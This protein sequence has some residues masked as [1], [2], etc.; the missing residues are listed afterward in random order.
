[1]T[2]RVSIVTFLS[3]LSFSGLSQVTRDVD[4]F[5][6]LVKQV[7]FDIESSPANADYYAIR[8]WAFYSLDSLSQANK[9]Y[10]RAI[11]LNDKNPDFYAGRGKIFFLQKD[12]E[13]SIKDFDRAIQMSVVVNLSLYL[14]RGVAYEKLGQYDLAL[15]D[16]NYV[17]SKEP[18]NQLALFKR[19]ELFSFK[20]EAYDEAIK[21]WMLLNSL[22]TE[23][24]SLRSIITSSLGFSI[25]KKG[26]FDESMRLFSKSIDIFPGNALCYLYRGK[27]LE[28]AGRVDEACKDFFFASNLGLD[29]PDILIN[30]KN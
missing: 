6:T 22:D 1:M 16:F 30:C 4:Y 3:L 18:I 8:A 12:F 13:N 20:F 15:D 5:V 7:T 28:S 24:D 23:S 25:G 29:F 19:A 27:I 14:N 11:F 9:D 26:N 2:I 21:D 17:L 10:S